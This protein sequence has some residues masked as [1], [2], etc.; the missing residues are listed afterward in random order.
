M[1]I[2][3]APT[4]DGLEARLKALQVVDADIAEL[5]RLDADD[6]SPVDSEL[7]QLLSERVETAATAMQELRAAD[8]E[9]LRNPSAG[10]GFV[11]AL[12]RANKTMNEAATVSEDLLPSVR[13]EQQRT[14][15]QAGDLFGSDEPIHIKPKD[16]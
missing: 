6:A 2:L 12:L 10:L 7:A 3:N 16:S 14:A 15:R 9:A 4:V 8:L 11:I 13:A 5:L 1:K